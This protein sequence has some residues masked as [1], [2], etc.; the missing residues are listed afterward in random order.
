MG[1]KASPWKYF[2]QRIM[3]RTDTIGVDGM[4]PAYLQQ[5]WESQHGKCAYSGLPMLLPDTL[6]DSCRTMRFSD[7][8]NPILCGSVDRIDSAL[9]Y[10]PGN[11]QFVCRGINHLKSDAQ[12]H[13]VMA[14]L[15]LYKQK[16]LTE[17]AATGT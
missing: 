3:E 14:F 5:L 8:C 4:N 17:A 16:L 9:P 2:W 1:R 11:V 6:E 13:Q 15:D 10:Q 7:E 12:G